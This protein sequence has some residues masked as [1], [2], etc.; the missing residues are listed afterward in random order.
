[1]LVEEG[2]EDPLGAVVTLSKTA[3]RP[4]GINSCFMT[5]STFSSLEW[6]ATDVARELQSASVTSS[7]MLK[8][9]ILE[10]ELFVT[11]SAFFLV[12]MHPL[13]VTA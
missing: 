6:K 13:N 8:Q 10:L 5:L 2:G 7:N 1:M 11:V 12:S 3:L 9:T 4:T